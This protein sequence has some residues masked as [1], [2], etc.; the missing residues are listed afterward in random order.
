[1]YHDLVNH[2]SLRCLFEFLIE[3]CEN[4]TGLFSLFLT[5]AEDRQPNNTSGRIGKEL[6]GQAKGKDTI[7][8]TTFFI[9]FTKDYGIIS[10]LFFRFVHYHSPSI[11]C[12][13]MYAM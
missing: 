12:F 9:V 2:D 3:Q 7:L 4:V 5:W 8:R 11:Y 1:M 13:Y 6:L 10:P